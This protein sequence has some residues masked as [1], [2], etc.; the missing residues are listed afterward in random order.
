MRPSATA[1][2]SISIAC[3]PILACNEPMSGPPAASLR[4]AAVAK[5]SVERMINSDFHCV[6]WFVCTSYCVLNSPSVFSPLTAA[7]ATFALNAAE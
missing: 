5:I 1:K 4:S 7:K 6:I 2:K 3:W